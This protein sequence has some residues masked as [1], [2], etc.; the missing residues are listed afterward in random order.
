[1]R[2]GAAEII[3]SRLA[4]GFMLN[5]GDNFQNFKSKM[6]GQICCE[7]KQWCDYQ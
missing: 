2:V 4:K 7:K 5:V 3:K 1:M 6:V